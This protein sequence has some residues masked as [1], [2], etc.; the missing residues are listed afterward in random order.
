[1]FAQPLAHCPFTPC[2]RQLEPEVQIGKTRIINAHS[3]T[4]I[5]N[6]QGKISLCHGS[7]VPNRR[8]LT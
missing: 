3:K 7:N 1:M 2:F 5:D 6:E 8:H 4:D